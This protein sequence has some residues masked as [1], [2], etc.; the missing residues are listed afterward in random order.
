MMKNEPI[1]KDPRVHDWGGGRDSQTGDL[2]QNIMIKNLQSIRKAETEILGNIVMNPAAINPLIN[3]F[4][5]NPQGINIYGAGMI[6]R[7]LAKKLSEGGVKVNCLIDWNIRGNLDNIP[8][9]H[10]KEV[11]PAY[12]N[13][14]ILITDFEMPPVMNMILKN[15]GY[16]GKFLMINKPQNEQKILNA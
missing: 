4:N 5:S 10:P 3:Q 16:T 7:V 8:I 11:P 9:I 6:G 1:F 13:L 14:D 2:P 12:R 15:G